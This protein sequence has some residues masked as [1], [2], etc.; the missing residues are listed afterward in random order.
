MRLLMRG[1]LAF[2]LLVES[3]G[4]AG[5][6]A[7]AQTLR[8][9]AGGAPL[10]P[11]VGAAAAGSHTAPGPVAGPATRAALTT[12]PRALVLS[13]PSVAPAAGSKAAGAATA[14]TTPAGAP[15]LAL[16]GAGRKAEP[17]AASKTSDPSPQ[18]SPRF[19]GRGRDAAA[20]GPRGVWTPALE[21]LRQWLKAG[22]REEVPNGAFRESR[23]SLSPAERSAGMAGRAA[24]AA[25][26]ASKERL[27]AGALALPAAAGG[28]GAAASALL[29]P[30]A[31]AA[32]LLSA[33]LIVSVL[34]HETAHLWGLKHWGDDT[35]E[36]AGRASLNPLRQIDPVGTVIL[37]AVSLLLSLSTIGFPLVFGWAKPVPVDFNKL[38]NPKRDAAKVAMM[39]PLANIGVA[40]FA[41]AAYF[42]L[43]ATGVLPAAGIAAGAIAALAQMNVALALFNLL[44]LPHLDGGKLLVRFMPRRAYH[45][46]WTHNPELPKEYQGIYRRIYEGP[47]NLLSHL[48]FRSQKAVNRLTRGVVLVTLAGFY[49]ALAAMGAAPLLFLALP[50]TYDY[51]C[52]HEKIRSQA[53][54]DEIR[55]LMQEWTKVVLQIASDLGAESE[56]NAF[57]TEHGLKNAVEDLV[58]ELMDDEKFR[59]LAPDEQIKFFMEKYREYAVKYL[60]EKAFSEDSEETIRKILADARNDPFYERLAGWLKKHEIFQ[61]WRSPHEKKKLKE[62]LDEAVNGKTRTNGGNNMG[63]WML[64][65][66]ALAGLGMGTPDGLGWAAA[67][68]LGLV[69]MF[70]TVGSGGSA[71]DPDAPLTDSATRKLRPEVRREERPHDVRVVF[72]PAVTAARGDEILQGLGLADIPKTARPMGTRYHVILRP[73]T[74]ERAAQAARAL[75]ENSLTTEVFAAQEVAEGL[76]WQPEAPA[77]QPIP[78]LAPVAPA[79]PEPKKVADAGVAPRDLMVVFERNVGWEEAHGVLTRNGVVVPE[80]PG[81]RGDM[82]DGSWSIR[83]TLATP[84]VA[85]EKAASLGAEPKVK[86]VSTNPETFELDPWAEESPEPSPQPAPPPAEPEREREAEAQAAPEP[87]EP[88]KPE[89]RDVQKAF[90]EWLGKK[91]LLDG[92]PLKPQQLALLLRFLKPVTYKPEAPSMP[93]IARTKEIQ[94][95]LPIL[96]SPRGMRN[97]VVFVGEAGVGKT[98]IVEGI[99]QLIEESERA[100]AAGAGSYLDVKRLKGRWFLDFNIDEMLSPG[101]D[102]DPIA[103]FKEVVRLVGLLNDPDAS[104][105]NET[106]LLFDEIHKLFQDPNGRKIANF[107][108]GPLR[109]GRLSVAA[110]VTSAEYKEYIEKDD[111]FRR[112]LE[113]IEVK[114]PTVEQAI[115]MLRGL[116]PTLEARHSTT[117]SDEAITAAAKLS[118]QFDKTNFLPDK[119]IKLVQDSAELSRPD[120]LRARLSLEIRE[121]WRKLA[122]AAHEAR[123]TL[124]DKGIASA[125][126]LP[127]EGYN[128]IAELA[129]EA[130]SL[131]G[132]LDAVRDGTSR[133]TPDVVKKMLA[134]KTGIASGQLTL[135]EDDASRYVTMESEVGQRVVNQDRAL[136]ALANAIRRNKAGIS[137]PNRPMGKFLMVGPTGVGKTHLAKE[138]AR[139]LF[140]DPN[141]M[142]RFDMSEFMEEHTWTRLT[143]APP[144]YVG[145]D[146]GGQLTEAVRQKPYSVILFD[147]IEKAHPKV[148]NILL[149]ILDDGRLTDGKGRTVDFKNTVILFTS[150]VGMAAVDYEKYERQLELETDELKRAG[151]EARWDAEIE[152]AVEE[153]VRAHFRP[154]LLNRM[155]QNPDS[156]KQWIVFNRL[157]RENVK[158]IARIQVA[159][160]KELL[161]ERH[162]IS[163]DIAEDV[164]EL[165]AQAGFSPAFGARPMTA[166]IEKLI[167]DPLAKWILERRASDP[168][169]A[170]GDEVIRIGASD[171]ATT[172]A[173]ELRPRV[174]PA[175][176]TLEGTAERLARAVL[177]RVE[178]AVDG[179]GSVHDPEELDGLF[180]SL[181]REPGAAAAQVGPAAAAPARGAVLAPDTPLALPAGANAVVALH[182]NPGKKDERVNA[183]KAALLERVDDGNWPAAVRDALEGAGV[184]EGWLKIFVR[185][186]KQNAG[187]LPVELVTETTPDVIRVLVHRDGA[188]SGEERKVLAAHFSGEPTASLED[189]Q[190]LA[191]RL[192]LGST[193]VWN[194][195]WLDLHRRLH[196]LPGAR[197]GFVAG[198]QARGGSGVDY[199]LEIPRDRPE[200]RVPPVADDPR[201]AGLTL[202][203]SREFAKTKQL[204][205]RVASSPSDDGHSAK[206]AAATGF[207]LLAVPEDV[208]AARQWVR[209]RGWTDRGMTTDKLRAQ[210]PMVMLASNVLERFGNAADIPVVEAMMAKYGEATS[211]YDIPARQA[212]ASALAALYA[213][214]GREAV[215]QAKWGTKTHADVKEA[216]D[217]ALGQVGVHEDLSVLQDAPLPRARLLKRVDPEAFGKWLAESWPPAKKADGSYDSSAWTRRGDRERMA[218]FEQVGAKAEPTEE[219]LAALGDALGQR[220]E[221][222]RVVLYVAAKAWADVASRLGRVQAIDDRLKKFMDTHSLTSYNGADDWAI[223]MGILHAL[224]E[225]GTPASL[226]TLEAVLGSSD[227]GVQA[228]FEQPRFR[229]PVVWGRIVARH[230]LLGELMTPLRGAEGK[231]LPSRIEEMLTSKYPTEAAA[232]LY[233]IA[234]SRRDSGL[235]AP[236]P[237]APSGPAPEVAGK[238]SSS[239]SASSTP[240]R[241]FGNRWD[242]I[243]RR[244]FGH[245][246]WDPYPDY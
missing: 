24:I 101:A 180:R 55:L 183:A 90:V 219:D 88:A 17:L 224:E 102:E 79:A 241:P 153:G 66:L 47:A 150:N 229:M 193:M 228:Y 4:L 120:N 159:E 108:K 126:A 35:P 165:L 207:R 175:R 151:I 139:F 74:A 60:K 232:A 56:S 109:D 179:Q 98:A 220:Y 62:G 43:T 129:R 144:S 238:G 233:A 130:A 45:E 211:H 1:T 213:R 54:V 187:E 200:D 39:G 9:P 148:L 94:K 227:S 93:V 67:A 181:S 231:V 15:A 82:Q 11:G 235:G 239:P 246:H 163:L 107:L 52:I 177:E 137:N 182:N 174:A 123:E 167:I 190:A 209:E 10:V 226:S 122:L 72:A 51:W 5:Y 132:A 106:I 156:K 81:D 184:A 113:K 234:F 237:P 33:G 86:R 198:T 171:D 97:S 80:E 208:R 71:P 78:E 8:A 76:G 138:L 3:P 69:A 105:G 57:E 87:A 29:A 49:A 203:Q 28:L 143:G 164:F 23:S 104:R 168:A 100:A 131:Y 154:E 147:E 65:P 157:N 121:A 16:G 191:D 119:A 244:R 84:Q 155:D 128:K 85:A 95:A 112:R 161:K 212:L 26:H 194:Y 58:D 124:S 25:R 32:G 197:L 103:M 221:S 77:Q 53:A 96:L 185:Q 146:E 27:L 158:K 37:P 63:G 186:A 140:K 6:S 89:P 176:A 110:T 204:M 236:T 242:Y 34:L 206:I 44:P 92:Q 173:A 117:I 160:F 142:I 118:H 243:S 14:D 20:E 202:H 152:T 116:R 30:S 50:C 59:A 99:A 31:G 222:N 240:P 216:L 46:H 192:A 70:G 230:R 166:A 12:V 75:A 40:A 48:P 205:L 134:E 162:G 178:E 195:I 127:I 201:L 2:L 245:D 196:G 19:A 215:L 41:G 13:L 225:A 38:P 170:D 210:W 115:E 135:G 169:P 42:A 141:A 133:T 36:R 189:A 7:V 217:L 125:L 188:L 218:I 18:P 223:L 136:R 73:A 64:V 61:K 22:R 68:A 149:Q 172:F 199:W 91:Q 114:E 83:L 21:Q 111:A 214:A 145:Y